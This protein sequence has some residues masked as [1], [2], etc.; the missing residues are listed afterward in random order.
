MVK[1]GEEEGPG[2]QGTQ[3]GA[4][5]ER[6]KPSPVGRREPGMRS[7]LKGHRIRFVLWLQVNLMQT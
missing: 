3:R 4:R 2:Q 5:S 7:E 6:L 1:A